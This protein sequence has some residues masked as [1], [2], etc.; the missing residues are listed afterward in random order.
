M[1]YQFGAV[2]RQKG[3]TDDGRQFSTNSLRLNSIAPCLVC[4]KPVELLTQE[5]AAELFNTDTQDIEFLA[6]H[7]DL[8]RIHNR[9]GR[10]MI[11]SISLFECFESRQ[12][13]L[14]A[15]HYVE[16]LYSR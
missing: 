7:G 11:C 10:V 13:R 2:R 6:K 16:K 4:G 3:K 15:S 12:T 5:A 9:T 14:L 1:A 8:H